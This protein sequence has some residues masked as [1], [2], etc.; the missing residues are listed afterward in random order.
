MFDLTRLRL[1]RELAHRGTMTAAGAALGLTSSAVSQQIATLE[2]EAK[3]KLLERVGRRVRLTAEGERLAAHAETILQAVERAALDLTPERGGIAG[4]LEIACFPTFA[5]ACLLPAATRA[6]RRHPGL[7]VVIRELEPVDAV[8][9]VR[10]GPAHLAITF[11]YNLVPK[12]DI[13]GLVT[14][15]LLEEPVLLALPKQGRRQPEPVP[16][17]RLVNADW[18][19]GSRQTDDRRLAERACAIAGFAPRMSHTIDDYDLLLRMVEAGLGIGF[20]PE[21]ALRFSG[22]KSIA[23]R[24][25]SGPA[26]RRTIQAVTRPALAASPLLAALLSELKAKPFQRRATSA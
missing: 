26:L 21:L 22:A 2:R 24:T 18:I 9:A 13:A 12:P 4:T 20:I 11:A 19:V 6:R 15:P 17:A 14:Y 25:A 23:I 5:K 8:E 1:F 16:L 3:V 7:V 10:N